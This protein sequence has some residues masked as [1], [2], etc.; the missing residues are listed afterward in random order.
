MTGLPPDSRFT[1]PIRLSQIQNGRT[2]GGQP[3]LPGP[4]IAVIVAS[5]G[6]SHGDKTHTYYVRGVPVGRTTVGKVDNSRM[7]RWCIFPDGS[8]QLVN[9]GN[10]TWRLIK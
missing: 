9:E 2:Y 7:Y 5:W 4:D 3:G 6:P 1:A 8:W 10:I